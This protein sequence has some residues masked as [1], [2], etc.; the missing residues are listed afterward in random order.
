MWTLH[1]KKLFQVCFVMPLRFQ[2]LFSL[3]LGC[4]NNQINMTTIFICLVKQK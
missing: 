4:D 3:L 2:D 1:G